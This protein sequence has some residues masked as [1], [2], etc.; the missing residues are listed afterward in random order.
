MHLIYVLK[1]TGAAVQFKCVGPNHN[2]VLNMTWEN[3]EGENTGFDV[4]VSNNSKVIYHGTESTISGTYVHTT[5][6]L[7]YSTKYDVTIYTVGKG[8]W[9]VKK[10][11]CTTGITGTICE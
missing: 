8:K 3:P 5:R 4:T 6:H 7:A 2:P 10:T 1:D 9:G 11:T